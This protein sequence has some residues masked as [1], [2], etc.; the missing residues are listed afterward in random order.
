MLFIFLYIYILYLYIYILKS[1]FVYTLDRLI[2]YYYRRTPA[3][4]HSPAA[5][6][7]KATKPSTSSSVIPP[8]A[9]VSPASWCSLSPPDASE[10]RAASP[11]RP[12]GSP[13]GEQEAPGFADFMRGV[14]V[15]FYN[16]G[17]TERKKLTRYLI[18]YP[19]ISLFVCLL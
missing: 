18:A 13:S 9:P 15:F 12:S 11:W 8:A 7:T 19:F 4:S 16:M 6:S 3:H 5:S 2:R 1:V 14:R 17:A 10:E